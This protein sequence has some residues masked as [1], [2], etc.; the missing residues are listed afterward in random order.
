MADVQDR[1]TAAKGPI[2]IVGTKGSGT[3]LLRL[4]L[5]SHPNI[6]VPQETGFARA[7]MSQQ[8]IPF[9][10]LGGSWWRKLGYTD[11]TF[12][13]H[14]RGFYETMFLH[15]A[16]EHGKQRWGEKTPFHLWHIKRLQ[17]VFPDA[18]FVGLARHP[19]G[20]IRSLQ[21]RFD[22]SVQHGIDHWTSANPE[23]LQQAAALGERFALCRYE[24][25][26]LQ[27]EATMRELLE[28]LGEPWSPA[29]LQHHVVHSERGTQQEVEGQTRTDEPI[30][31]SRV[32]R[33]VDEMRPEDRDLI[34]RRTRRMA[35]VYG[36][37]LDEPA[38]TE[39]LGADGRALLTGVQ[40]AERLQT[41]QIPQLLDQPFPRLIDMPMDPRRV[42][43]VQR[44]KGRAVQREA[45]SATAPRQGAPK[46]EPAKRQPA[47]PTATQPPSLPRKIARRLPPSVKRAL[48]EMIS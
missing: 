38:P 14:L 20:N 29:V 48:R 34:T 9:W 26:V 44:K 42:T 35:V 7:L 16:A 1:A 4:I 3:T 33:W 10:G 2:F 6:A 43:L 12:R 27:P 46:R 8:Q 45:A 25:L 11:D 37:T 13:Q 24:D 47:K 36:Y 30:D 41:L 19:G 17:E 40:I 28:W 31:E 21:T 39:P 15:Y 5:D 18:V 22:Y 23:M 32:T